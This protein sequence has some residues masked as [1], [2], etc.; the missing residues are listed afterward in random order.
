[1]KNQDKEGS[2]PAPDGYDFPMSGEDA[3]SFLA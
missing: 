3:I 2:F 1:M